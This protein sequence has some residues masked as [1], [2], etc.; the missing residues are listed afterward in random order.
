[1]ADS[2]SLT[3]L[4][5]E[6]QGAV[7]ALPGRPWDYIAAEDD[8]VFVRRG[9]LTFDLGQSERSTITAAVNLLYSLMEVARAAGEHNDECCYHCSRTYD[10]NDRL[11]ALRDAIALHLEEK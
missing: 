8:Y 6:L 9:K 2:R 11:I 4:L 5:D 7:G 10:L 1:M 3:E